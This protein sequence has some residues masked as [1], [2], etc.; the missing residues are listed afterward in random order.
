[1]DQSPSSS[2]ADAQ[3]MSFEEAMSAAIAKET[4]YRK[5][6][7]DIKDLTA[8]LDAYEADKR[9]F[10][11]NPVKFIRN[12]APDAKPSELAEAVWFDDLGPAAP[13]EYHLQK[14]VREIKSTL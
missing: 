1:M 13:K 10:L 2:S 12:L 14:E 11:A 5:Y 3:Q 7:S 8:R 9:A 4:E 6:E